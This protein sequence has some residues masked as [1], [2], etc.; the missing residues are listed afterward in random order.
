MINGLITIVITGIGLAGGGVFCLRLRARS[1]CSEPKRAVR[2]RTGSQLA[3]SKIPVVRELVRERA[4]GDLEPQ[5]AKAFRPIRTAPD[6]QEISK[7]LRGL[8]QRKWG[9]LIFAEAVS[10]PR[11]AATA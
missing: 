11:S 10:L 2:G 8:C 6:V 1:L 5:R 9:T 7:G 4:C 3:F